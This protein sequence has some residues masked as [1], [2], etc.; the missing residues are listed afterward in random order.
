[1]TDTKLSMAT[2]FRG[3]L[4][5]IIDVETGGTNPQTDALLEIAAII[6][7]FDTNDR[8]QIVSS[9]HEHVEPFPGGV[10]S[11]E[12]LQFNKIDPH[13][14]FR[15]AVPE[16]KALHVL[17]K[18]VSNAIKENNCQRAVLVGHHAWFDLFFLKAAVERSGIKRNPFHPFTTFDT[19]TLGAIFYGQ[20]VLAKAVAAAGLDFDSNNAHSALYDAERTAAFFCEV[21]NTHR[22]LIN[23]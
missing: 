9:I 16:K 14:P 10:L 4:P 18:C 12:A 13:H 11:P 5:V 2:R 3:F 23:Q 7:G 21:V 8:L 20:T 22:D 19:A 17:F 15:F 1:M 6:L